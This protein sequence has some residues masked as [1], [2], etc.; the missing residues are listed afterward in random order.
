MIRHLAETIDRR[1]F[2]LTVCCLK[3]RGSIGDELVKAGIEVVSFEETKP[4]KVDYF[5]FRKVLRLIRERD[6]QVVHTHTAHG[7]VDAGLCRVLRPSLV[8]LARKARTAPPS[9]A[10]GAADPVKD[11]KPA[12]ANDAT[13]AEAVPGAGEAPPGGNAS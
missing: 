8:A 2:N 13:A 7:L 10:N 4:E 11:E 12:E 5:T 1:R 3:Q 6:I 9:P